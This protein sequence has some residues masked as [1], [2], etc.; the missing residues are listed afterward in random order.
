MGMNVRM[1]KLN[2]GALQANNINAS[3]NNYDFE[4]WREL[5]Y[6][7]MI[8]TEIMSKKI[9][10]NFIAPILYKVDTK[11]NID[12]NKLEKIKLNGKSTINFDE[13]IKKEKKINDKTIYSHGLELKVGLAPGATV[14]V[15]NVVEKTVDLTDD[16]KKTLILLTEAPT[17]NI[18]KWASSDYEAFGTVRK[19]VAT[20]YHSDD[21]WKSILFQMVYIFSVLQEKGIFIP[22]ISLERNFF[23]KDIFSDANAIGSWI[24]RI[25]NVDYY[26]P[27]YG[28]ILQFDS[29][30]GDPTDNETSKYNH[31]IYNSIFGEDDIKNNEIK[32]KI[33]EQFKDF[34]IASNFMTAVSKNTKISEGTFDLI[35]KIRESATTDI[36]DIFS[37]ELFINFV[38][39]RVGT[40]L[41]KSER[42]NINTMTRP[43]FNK[44]KLMVCETRNQEYK[45][46]VYLNEATAFKKRIITR[47]DNINKI[48]EVFNSSLYGYPE[49]ERV[50]PDSSKQFKYDDNHIYE[51]Y[52]LEK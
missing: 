3:I 36:K 33:L 50:L 7:E 51:T 52:N 49:S 16:S 18:L 2:K 37:S 31:K 21:V 28:Y 24:Y 4:V 47:D 20:G 26:I 9:A 48:M 19:M 32:T 35:R 25:N 23:I 29:S 13:M 5:K 14:N 1:Y 34:M 46:V 38:H 6:Y 27:N 17:T 40:L 30:Y 12:W 39:N 43:N 15:N 45:W 10:P 44:S 41:L 42:E 11:S 22:N 8:K